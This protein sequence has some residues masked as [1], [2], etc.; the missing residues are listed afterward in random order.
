VSLQWSNA[1]IVEKTFLKTALYIVR[2]AGLLFAWIVRQ[3]GI[4]LTVVNCGKLRQTWK[5]QKQKKKPKRFALVFRFLSLCSDCEE[6]WEAEE[7]LD[8]L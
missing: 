4:V 2:C 1:M 8:F 6:T 3:R 5:T 7:D